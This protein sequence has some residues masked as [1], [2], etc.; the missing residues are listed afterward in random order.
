M[1]DDHIPFLRRGVPVLHVISVP[2]PPTWHT[3]DDDLAHVDRPTTMHLLGLAR[4]FV[5][6]YFDLGV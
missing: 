1:E 6:A 5:A 2:F 3:K 4:A